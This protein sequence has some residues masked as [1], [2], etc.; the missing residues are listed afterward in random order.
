VPASPPAGSA[1]SRRRKARRLY[2]ASI[3]WPFA[4]AGEN[5]AERLGKRPPLDGRRFTMNYKVIH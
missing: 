1:A 5:T 3:G 2:G 4:I